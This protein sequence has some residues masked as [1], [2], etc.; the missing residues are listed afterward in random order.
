MAPIY[1]SYDDLDSDLPYF[2]SRPPTLHSIK[3]APH[4]S[5]EDAHLAYKF[6]SLPE[7]ELREDIERKGQSFLAYDHSKHALA[8]NVYEH[9]SAPEQTFGP[10]YG[11]QVD[12]FMD[13]K[14]T[15]QEVFGPDDPWEE[16]VHVNGKSLRDGSHWTV[17]RLQR[18]LSRRELDTSG[19]R[20]D[21]EDRLYDD[22]RHRLLPR[23]D[24]SHW[25]ISRKGHKKQHAI[26]F[27]PRNGL[28]ALDMYTSAIKLSPHNP[29]YW[30][31]RAYCHYRLSF[32]DLALGDAYRALL[33]CEAMRDM[34]IHSYTRGL[35]ERARHAVEQHIYSIPSEDKISPETKLLRGTGIIAFTPTLELTI[36]NII[37]LSLLALQCWDDYDA[38]ERFSV[39]EFDIAR[40]QLA[41][42]RPDHWTVDQEPL[43]RIRQRRE[44][45]DL[46]FQEKKSGACPGARKYP[47]DADD[48]NRYN[49]KFVDFVN[50]NLADGFPEKKCE[51]GIRPIPGRPDRQTLGMFATQPIKKNEL[52]FVSDPSMR[53]YLSINRL[54][55]D[56]PVVDARKPS[57]DNCGRM[58]SQRVVKRYRDQ[59]L[60]MF[61]KKH[62]EGCLCLMTEVP[63]YFCPK[64]ESIEPT[65]VEV[66][67]DCYHYKACGKDWQWLH[68]AMRPQVLETDDK[69]HLHHSNEDHGTFLSLV[70]REILDTTLLRRARTGDPTLMPH[71]LD[72]MIMLES[73]SDWDSQYFPFT[74]AANIQVPFDILMYMGVDIFSDLAFDVWT[75]QTVL[76]KL[77]ASVVPGDTRLRE[78]LEAAK[79][80]DFPTPSDQDRMHSVCSIMPAGAQ[81][82]Q[83]GDTARRRLTGSWCGPQRI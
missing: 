50:K 45:D 14:W 13:K 74:L 47:Y 27:T 83:A 33:I 11:S 48:K 2:P 44:P 25:G 4:V 8:K 31:S 81:T 36:F 59:A 57:C 17:K 26:R 39:A 32:F 65:C 52:I 60:D 9:L 66:A 69:P 70:L 37:T 19:R 82:T 40:R 28:N 58:I 68:D 43:A 10:L 67:R 30:L 61:L 20:Q 35:E 29:V 63:I 56:E 7:A 42:L 38:M 6:W 62:S 54:K 51:V 22:E 75:I 71:E 24:L 16:D 5:P 34:E 64:E 78:P 53:G 23:N 3:W 73:H 72:E 21:L 77:Y 41:S 80:K 1:Y 55:S 15:Y 79:E 49:K 76:K 18:E 12:N 46:L